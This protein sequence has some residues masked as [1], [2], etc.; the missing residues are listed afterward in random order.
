MKTFQWQYKG[1]EGT[2]NADN[3][4]E[5]KVLIA[6]V[7][8]TGSDN[9]STRIPKG[10]KIKSLG[11]AKADTKQVSATTDVKEHVL[12]SNEPCKQM[13]ELLWMELTKD[14]KFTNCI[15]KFKDGHYTYIGDK[16]AE[17]I[18]PKGY[19]CCKFVTW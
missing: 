13:H 6:G 8:R 1:R 3:A 12:T 16:G 10:T 15:I 4:K 18:L 14:T 19:E 7:L 9:S 2:V 11:K 17:L 5:A